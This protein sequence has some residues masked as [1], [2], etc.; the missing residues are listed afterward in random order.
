MFV[1]YNFLTIIISFQCKIDKM[2]MFHAI[3]KFVDHCAGGTSLKKQ[4]GV[5]VSS[6][7]LKF[8]VQ[9]GTFL[10]YILS[11]CILVI[12]FAYYFVFCVRLQIVCGRIFNQL[13]NLNYFCVQILKWPHNSDNRTHIETSLKL[14]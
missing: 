10:Y 1:L 3:V 13:S 4:L 12:S 14:Q 5:Y 2:I 7:T 11:I 8:K 9:I 6:R